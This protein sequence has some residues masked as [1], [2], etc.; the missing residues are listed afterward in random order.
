MFQESLEIPPPAHAVHEVQ[1]RLRHIQTRDLKSSP[2]QRRQPQ[3]SHN[4]V[5]AKK[6]LGA[7]LRIVIYHQIVDIESWAWQHLNVHRPDV[8]RASNRCTDGGD[9]PGF[10]TRSSG[11]QYK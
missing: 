6:R 4:F 1:T 5:G 9:D 2:Q 3:R 7:K 10:E 11:P 8:N